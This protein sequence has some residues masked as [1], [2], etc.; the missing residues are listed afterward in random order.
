LRI[1][2]NL[3]THQGGGFARETQVSA[4][5]QGPEFAA[6]CAACDVVR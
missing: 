6:T 4:L 1:C 3:V 5:H 2:G